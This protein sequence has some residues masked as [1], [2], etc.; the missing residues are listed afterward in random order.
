MAISNRPSDLNQLAKRIVDISTGS[1][2]EPELSP[3]QQ[4]GRL[5]GLVGGKARADK[6]SKKRRSEIAKQA[7]EARWKT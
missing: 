7:A 1:A 3:K 4:A 6:L 2:S 5:G